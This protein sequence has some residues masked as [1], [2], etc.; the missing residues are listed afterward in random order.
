MHWLHSVDQL[1]FHVGSNCHTTDEYYRVLHELLEDRQFA[2]VSAFAESKRNEG[3]IS[4]SAEVFNDKK[5]NKNARLRA[6]ATLVQTKSRTLIATPALD[7]ARLEIWAILQLIELVEPLRNKHEPLPLANQNIQY[8]ENIL[9]LAWKAF[10]ERK[11]FGATSAETTAQLLSRDLEISFDN[12]QTRE[13]L[14]ATV[15]HQL[16]TPFL[17]CMTPARMADFAKTVKDRLQDCDPMR[18]C[19]ATFESNYMERLL[20]GTDISGLGFGRSGTQAP[21]KSIEG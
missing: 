6:E 15:F 1:I 20:D 17:N 18:R 8:A 16:R 12:V 2:V 14:Y 13:Q 10:V 11:T 21:T 3:A 19:I 9:D 4:Q 5:E 7:A